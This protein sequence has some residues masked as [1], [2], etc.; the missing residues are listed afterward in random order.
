MSLSY[1][2]SSRQCT[3]D[4]FK[5]DSCTGPTTSNKCRRASKIVWPSVNSSPCEG[6]LHI[7]QHVSK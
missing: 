5:P 2:Y 3:E 6:F 4:P 7:Q 1:R